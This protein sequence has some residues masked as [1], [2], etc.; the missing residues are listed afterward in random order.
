MI[1]MGRFLV[2]L[3]QNPTMTSNDPVQFQDPQ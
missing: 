1:I 2:D 3:G